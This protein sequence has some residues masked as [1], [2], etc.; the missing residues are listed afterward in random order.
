MGVEDFL[1]TTG[2]QRYDRERDAAMVAKLHDAR[3][4]KPQFNESDAF[5][6]YIPNTR[7]PPRYYKS[8]IVYTNPYN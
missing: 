1:S 5:I 7:A 2:S 4:P 8:F 6:P 3:T